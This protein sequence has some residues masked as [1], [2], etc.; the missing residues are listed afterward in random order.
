MAKWQCCRRACDPRLPAAGPFWRAVAC[1]HGRMPRC[2]RLLPPVACMMPVCSPGCLTCHR[3]PWL[4]D[5]FRGGHQQRRHAAHA[6]PAPAQA[7]ARRRRKR[8]QP[9]SCVPLRC[10][11]PRV[12]VA[13]TGGLPWESMPASARHAAQFLSLVVF[14]CML[15]RLE[16]N[17]IC[18]VTAYMCV[19][20]APPSERQGMPAC[21][22]SWLHDGHVCGGRRSHQR[23]VTH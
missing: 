20:R 23:S 6:A 21:Q 4:G 13:R 19:T 22:L 16:V 8:V 17:G 14:S 1:M 12:C 9:L 10:L 7:A 18:H 5:R 2:Q 3:A 15:S 11:L